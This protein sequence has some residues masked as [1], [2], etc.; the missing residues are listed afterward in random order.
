MFACVGLAARP[1]QWCFP[2]IASA[3][4]VLVFVLRDT[5]GGTRHRE[6]NSRPCGL[7]VWLLYG[8]SCSACRSITL[9]AWTHHSAFVPAYR[10]AVPAALQS[11]LHLPC[12]HARLSS[13]CFL[14]AYQVASSCLHVPHAPTWVPGSQVTVELGV[15]LQAPSLSKVVLG[16]A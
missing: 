3:G 9:F 1:P 6:C 11:T 10:R 8:G 2:C 7:L 12:M 13:T 16:R 14:F 15:C 4:L 5:E